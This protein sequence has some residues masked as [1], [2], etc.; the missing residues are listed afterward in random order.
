MLLFLIRHSTPVVDASQPSNVWKLSAAGM[1]RAAQLAE[2]LSGRGIQLIV[3]STEVKAIQTAEML[4]D[5]LGVQTEA[6]DGLHEHERSYPRDFAANQTEF[7]ARIAGL[8]AEPDSLV[9]GDETAHQ[10]SLRFE[11]ALQRVIARHPDKTLAVVA[12]GTAI[13]LFIARYNDLDGFAFW[14]SLGMPACISLE[15]PGFKIIENWSP[16]KPHTP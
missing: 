5:H 3:S 8:F 7:K 11:A 16:A 13:S 9:F 6:T 15:I 12:H 4:A 2:H 14:Q 1:D 10:T